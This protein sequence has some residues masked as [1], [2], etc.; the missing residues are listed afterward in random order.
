MSHYTRDSGRSST[1]WDH[2]GWTPSTNKDQST[3]SSNSEW[4][5]RGTRGNSREHEGRRS[6]WDGGKAQGSADNTESVAMDGEEK[7]HGGEKGTEEDG[8][9]VRD[10]NE[11]A[12]GHEFRGDRKD[13]HCTAS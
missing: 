12:S 1:S 3:N 5:K 8:V 11:N 10:R 7:T 4:S 9:A 6:C 13:C 2:K